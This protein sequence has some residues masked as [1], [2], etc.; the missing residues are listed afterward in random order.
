MKAG[1]VKLELQALLGIPEAKRAPTVGP[2][3]R[4]AFERLAVTGNDAEWDPPTT[5]KRQ[6]ND[7]GL[8][9]VKHFEGLYLKAYKDP[10]GIWTIFYGHTGLQHRDGTVY[11]GRTGTRAEADQ[12]LRYDMGQFEARVSSL[13]KVPLEDNQF[14]AL[15]S[16]DF[17]TGGL[18]RSTLLR[19]LNDGDYSGAADQFRA[20]NRAGG[21][22]LAGLTRRRTAEAAMF[23]GKTA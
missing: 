11:P 6:I 8:D 20:W 19:K 2:L 12:L 15:V 13:V 3:T 22:V 16:F 18:H 23:R 10:V 21:R 1:L 14:A 5:G 4:A 17:N 9:L 7:A